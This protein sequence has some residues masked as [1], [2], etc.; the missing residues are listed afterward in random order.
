MISQSV[1]NPRILVL[2]LFK[3]PPPGTAPISR[4]PV[5]SPARTPILRRQ[6]NDGLAKNGEAGNGKIE[7]KVKE[8]ATAL[9]KR[10]PI[11]S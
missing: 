2:I 5:P 11:Y 7:E 4:E 1:K 8:Q 6:A 10:F 3:P 9:C